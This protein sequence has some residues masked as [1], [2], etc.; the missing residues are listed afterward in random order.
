MFRDRLILNFIVP[1]G[2]FHSIHARQLLIKKRTTDQK[3]LMLKMYYRNLT[4]QNAKVKDEKDL[5]QF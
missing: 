4:K 1:N 3:N 2:F 5:I